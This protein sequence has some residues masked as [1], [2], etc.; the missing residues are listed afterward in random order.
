ML[1][2]A[3]GLVTPLGSEETL[4]SCVPTCP[5]EEKVNKKKKKKQK[6]KQKN[7]VL[8]SM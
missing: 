8:I 2:E 4:G 6:Q 7:S 5:D 1:G 3:S